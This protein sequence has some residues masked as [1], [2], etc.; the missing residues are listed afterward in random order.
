MYLVSLVLLRFPQ[1]ERTLSCAE[2]NLRINPSFSWSKHKNNNRVV[3]EADIGVVIEADINIY[4]NAWKFGHQK[5]SLRRRVTKNWYA[6]AWKLGHKQHPR[7]LH[8][9]LNDER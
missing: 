8:V 6:N 2:Q 1:R 3:T 4:G 7:Q 9:K 5:H